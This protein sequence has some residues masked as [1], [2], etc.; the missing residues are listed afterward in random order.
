[1]RCSS[2]KSVAHSAIGA[3]GNAVATACSSGLSFFEGGLLFGSGQGMLRPGH[4]LAALEALQVVPA[5]LRRHRTTYLGRHPVGDVARPPAFGAI[6]GWPRERLAH[7][8]LQRR[9]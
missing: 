5:P 6:G 2:V 9:R 8:L 3:W 1:M 4:L 7:L